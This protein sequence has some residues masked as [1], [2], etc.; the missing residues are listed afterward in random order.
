MT[1][2]IGGYIF[3]GWYFLVNTLDEKSGI[4]AIGCEKDRKV[5]VLDVGESSNVRDRVKNHD[6]KDCW[7]R[8]CRGGTLKYAQYATPNKQQVGRKAVEQNI[9]KK[10]DIPCGKE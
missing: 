5:R 8:H 7:D 10:E 2:I 6:G 3:Q 4:Y 9:R 1:V